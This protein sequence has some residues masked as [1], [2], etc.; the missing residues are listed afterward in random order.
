[1]NVFEIKPNIYVLGQT[2]YVPDVERLL[3]SNPHVH[4]GTIVQLGNFLEDRHG[5][6]RAGWMQHTKE[7][8]QKRNCNLVLLRGDQDDTDLFSVQNDTIWCVNKTTVMGSCLFLP[9]GLTGDVYELN[10]LD[11]DQL[12][13]KAFVLETTRLLRSGIKTIFSIISPKDSENIYS[14]P[15]Y[16]VKRRELLDVRI[17][18]DVIKQNNN[19]CKINWYYFGGTYVAEDNITFTGID[20]NTLTTVVTK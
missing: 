5:Y 6:V 14:G 16:N 7:Q 15:A 1:M 13:Q 10:E 20:F 8:L 3:T 18:K 4:S 2:G 17:A 12:N 9:G 11:Y 19:T